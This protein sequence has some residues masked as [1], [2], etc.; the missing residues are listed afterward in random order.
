MKKYINLGRKKK[1]LA[2]P[3]SLKQD[4]PADSWAN[5]HL[6]TLAMLL[7]PG[8]PSGMQESASGPTA[9]IPQGIHMM[10]V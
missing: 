6:P 5:G 2:D 9:L 1:R 4:S 8:L 7:C 3:H 10:G